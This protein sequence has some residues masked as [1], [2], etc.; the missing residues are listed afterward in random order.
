[1]SYLQPEMPVGGRVVQVRRAVPILLGIEVNRGEPHIQLEGVFHRL[2]AE[3]EAVGA[4]GA[5]V[6]EAT[7]EQ[8]DAEATLDDTGLVLVLQELDADGIKG[9]G[10]ATAR[11]RV[12][13][14]DVAG[15][16]LCCETV[17]I[18]NQP[19]GTEIDT[20]A[21]IAVVYRI[22]DS[23]VDTVGIGDHRILRTFLVGEGVAD[24][25]GEEDG[26]FVP[27]LCGPTPDLPHSLFG[28]ITFT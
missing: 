6:G 15:E 18:D 21:R 14:Y 20:A 24:F 23:P 1:M 7:A 26:E 17:F 27:N 8:R 11:L 22:C 4:N 9:E 10:P 19:L 16:Q 3:F 5:V 28:K 12:G 13:A 25:V 2:D